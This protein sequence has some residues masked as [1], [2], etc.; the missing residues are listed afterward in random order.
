MAKRK[1]FPAGGVDQ[2]VLESGEDLVALRDLDQ[3]LCVALACPARG[4]DIDEATLALFDGDHDGRVRAPEIL[5]AI[6]FSSSH[7]P[8]QIRDRPSS[9]NMIGA[10]GL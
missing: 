2:V 1:L 7:L 3:K 5:E 10:P 9:P 8:V 6:D 4:T